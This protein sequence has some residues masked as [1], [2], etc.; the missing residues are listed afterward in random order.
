MYNHRKEKNLKKEIFEWARE[1]GVAVLIA[2]FI[3]KFMFAHIVIPTASM[4]PTIQCNDHIMV[5]KVS[6]Y[7]RDPERGEVVVFH[8]KEKELIKR[9][10]G[11]PGDVIDFHDG[12][13]YI[14]GQLIEEEYLQEAIETM[15][16]ETILIEPDANL[17][18]PYKIPEGNYFVMGDNRGNSKDS[19]YIGTVN[20][21]QIY[22]VAK[23]RIWPLKTL[24][25]I[26]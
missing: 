22:A 1:I 11:L 12:H 19:R 2:W 13:V 24:G 18:Y 9:V 15:P 10:I 4:V 3:T 16:A 5:N 23:F 6:M 26:Y 17:T 20:R 8:G 7:Y 25:N 14:N 21:K